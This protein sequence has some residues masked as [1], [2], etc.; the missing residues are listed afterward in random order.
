MYKAS[1]YY[2]PEDVMKL[3]GCKRTKAY[4]IIRAL[5]KELRDEGYYTYDGRVPKSRF[6]ERFYFGDVQAP[7]RSKKEA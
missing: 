4:N 3:V 5:N 1:G 7:K 2:Y 6:N